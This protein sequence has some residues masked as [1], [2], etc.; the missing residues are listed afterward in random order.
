MSGGCEKCRL[1]GRERIEKKEHNLVL[2]CNYLIRC[3]NQKNDLNKT[4]LVIL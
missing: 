4:L 3:M 2:N 1:I